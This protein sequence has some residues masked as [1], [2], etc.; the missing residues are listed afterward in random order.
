MRHRP[1]LSLVV[2]TRAAGLAAEPPAEAGVYLPEAVAVEAAEV[3]WPEAASRAAAEPR[4]GKT[5]APPSRSMRTP[6]GGQLVVQARLADVMVASS[7]EA[8]GSKQGEETS[9][10]DPLVRSQ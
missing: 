6:A 5:A 8:A 3:A 1:A 9:A 10:A 2:V 4:R 7:A